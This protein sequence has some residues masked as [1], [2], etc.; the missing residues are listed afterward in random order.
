MSEPKKKEVQRS[1]KLNIELPEEVAEGV[2]S[3]LAMIAHSNSE[4]VIDL[5]RLMPGLPKARVKARIILSPTHA[6][7][8]LHALQDNI[9]KYERA[10]GNIQ[11]T[12]DRP[13]Y[14]FAIGAGP[15]GE[16]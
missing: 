14:P 5:I 13:P 7:Q 6:K 8:L 4:F 15:I 1:A 3:N 16:A 9:K 2:Y 10:F 12:D 11:D